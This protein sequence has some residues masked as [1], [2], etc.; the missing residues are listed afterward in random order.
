MTVWDQSDDGV[1]EAQHSFSFAL[2]PSFFL[3]VQAYDPAVSR[4]LLV[5]E[6]CQKIPMTEKITSKFALRNDITCVHRP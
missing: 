5:A 2:F 6:R 4:L 1:D 3:P